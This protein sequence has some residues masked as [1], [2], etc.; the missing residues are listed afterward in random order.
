MA[1]TDIVISIKPED[2]ELVERLVKALEELNTNT[3]VHFLTDPLVPRV[4][5]EIVIKGA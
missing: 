4:I 2:K 3:R 5:H 1:N